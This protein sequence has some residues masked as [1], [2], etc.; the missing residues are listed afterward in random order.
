ME[1]IVLKQ[2]QTSVITDRLYLEL[3]FFLFFPFSIL[4]CV[5]VCVCVCVYVCVFFQVLEL[6][7]ELEE[8]VEQRQKAE[9]DAEKAIS[10]LRNAG[11]GWLINLKVFVEI[12]DFSQSGSL[13]NA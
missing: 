6:E 1:V 4:L 3:C 8:I 5:C 13:L 7:H 11:Q 9:K 2:L 10:N 12:A